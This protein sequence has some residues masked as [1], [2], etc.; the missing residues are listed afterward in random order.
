M[1]WEKIG[2]LVLA[3]AFI[4]FI[5][6]R[7]LQSAKDSPKGTSKDWMSFV[8]PIAAVIGFVVLLIMS[9]R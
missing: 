9:V 2:M 5:G 7:L 3:G 6:P 8:M 1:G 4:F